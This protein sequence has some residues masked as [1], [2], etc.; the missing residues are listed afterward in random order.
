MYILILDKH[1]NIDLKNDKINNLEQ[2]LDNMVDLLRSYGVDDEEILDNIG[3]YTN[4]TIE[5]NGEEN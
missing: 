4:I 5:E 1:Y 3:E 2:M